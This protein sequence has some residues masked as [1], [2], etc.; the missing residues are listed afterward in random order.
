MGPGGRQFNRSDDAWSEERVLDH[1]IKGCRSRALNQ[2]L[3]WG[4]LKQIFYLA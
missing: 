3:F 2:T 4:G 1:L